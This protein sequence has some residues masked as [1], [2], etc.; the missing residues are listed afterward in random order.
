MRNDRRFWTPSGEAVVQICTMN[1]EMT[2]FR[3]VVALRNVDTA[4]VTRE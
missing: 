1:F 2:Y 3:P 4:D